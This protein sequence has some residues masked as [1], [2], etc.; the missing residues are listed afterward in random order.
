MQMTT[1]DSNEIHKMNYGRTTGSNWRF[2]RR[3][4]RRSGELI[5]MV[6]FEQLR[7]FQ[8]FQVSTFSSGF[9]NS[10]LDWK[11]LES[12]NLVFNS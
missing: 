10:K 9:R 11:S 2:Q 7:N 4:R 8:E 3:W 6:I 12:K 5:Q 1:N